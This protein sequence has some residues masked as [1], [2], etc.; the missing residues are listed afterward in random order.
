MLIPLVSSTPYL[1]GSGIYVVDGAAFLQSHSIIRI[2]TATGYTHASCQPGGDLSRAGV[3][4][5]SF[6]PP[7]PVSLWEPVA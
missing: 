2:R 3:H 7:W 6:L 1:S 4:F 5:G